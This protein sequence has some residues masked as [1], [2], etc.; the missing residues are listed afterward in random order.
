MNAKPSGIG[1]AYMF[2]I[3]ARTPSTAIATTEPAAAAWLKSGLR[4]NV[5]TISEMTADGADHQDRVAAGEEEPAQVREEQRLAV[6]ARVEEDAVEVAIDGEHRERGE[7]RRAD[8]EQ[9]VGDRRWP[10]R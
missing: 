10:P 6:L 7:H 4:A 2:C 8:H 1:A 3:Q 9:D 5:G